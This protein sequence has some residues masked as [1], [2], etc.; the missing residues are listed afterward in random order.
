MEGLGRRQAEVCYEEVRLM[1]D[2]VDAGSDNL[3]DRAYRLFV[4]ILDRLTADS[5]LLFAGTYS[6]LDFVARRES[7]PNDLLRRLNAFRCRATGRDNDDSNLAEA[8]PFDVKALCFFIAAVYHTPVPE[9][10]VRRLPAT[11]PPLEYQG[12]VEGCIRGVVTRTDGSLLFLQPMDMDARE[13]AVCCAED[14]PFGDFTY[15]LSIVKT[16]TRVNVIRPTLKDGVYHPQLV[17]VMPDLLIDISAVAACFESYAD[18][19][20]AHL[21]NLLSPS[22]NSQAILLGNFAGQLLDEAVHNDS[23]PLPYAQ[24]ARSF[25]RQSAMKLATCPD[26]QPQF[27]EDAKAQQKNICNIVARQ[28]TQLQGYA[29]EKVLLEPSF[30]CEMLGLQGRMD[31]LQTDLRVL[32]EQKSGKKDW[33]GGHLEKHYVQML[34][35]LAL[36]HYNYDIPNNQIESCLLYSKY[37]DGLIKEGPAPKLLFDAMR[38]RN[39]IAVMME[40]LAEGKSRVLLDA[41]TP[42]QLKVKPMVDKFWTVYIRPKLDAV[43]APIHQADRLTRDYFHRMFTFV[44]REHIL[45]KVGTPAREASGLAALWNASM[46]EKQSAGN[47]LA[48]LVIKQLHDEGKGQGITEVT[49]SVEEAEGVYLPNFREADAVIVYA[50]HKNTVPDPTHTMVFRATMMRLE[51][52][53]VVIAL[54]AP[55][56]NKTV[57]HMGDENIRWALEHDCMETTF[58]TLYRS[59]AAILT[60]GVDRRKLILAQ[61]APEVNTGAVPV[62]GQSDASSLLR[63]FVKAKDYFL[64]IGPPGTGKTSLGLVAMLQ[65]ELAR[66]GTVL[67]LSYTN[68]AVNEICSKLVEQGID[69]LRL[70]NPL[71]CPERYQDFLLGKRAENCGNVQQV[72]NLIANARVMV[73]TTS[74]MLSNVDL[75]SLRAFSLS[76]V[77]EASQILEPHLLGILCAKHGRGEAIQRFVLIGDHK[78][79]PAVVQQSAN[80]SIVKE[81]NLRGIGLSDCRL[82]L[83]ERLLKVNAGRDD[84]VFHFTKQG[85]MH[86]D[87]AGF[88]NKA[89]YNDRLREVPLSHQLEDLSFADVDS[90]DPAQR[91]LSS[92]RLLFIASHQAPT[93]GMEKVNEEEARI[94]ARLV[95]AAYCLY[96]KDKSRGFDPD[97][98]VGVIVPYRHQIA[99]IRRELEKYG[100][101]QLMGISIDTVERFQGSQREVIIYGFT[102]QKPWQLDF[103][104]ANVFVEDGCI[105]DRKLNVALTRARQQMV[106]VGNPDLLKEVEVFAKLID[107]CKKHGTFCEYL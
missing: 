9:Q 20:L 46:G 101:P 51:A 78:Q 102:V 86:H 89:F 107:Y 67:L 27:H 68:R 59:V 38:I 106:V 19:H 71:A 4:A 97:A 47:I 66:G 12:R 63:R 53:E 48:P 13:V 11:F 44:A 73:S 83:F 37:P 14:S 16:G 62:S 49:L 43:L 84:I 80:D 32:V 36:L 90:G 88:A 7:L 10:L 42:D 55:Q 95:H 91:L 65:E 35:Y 40:Q 39:N 64:L 31:L 1:L 17:V 34:L 74:T 75:F 87:V 60:A 103:L 5:S 50:F 6:K 25:F 85:R 100:I 45:A 72:R 41:L 30:F 76:I 29:P 81:N 26:M 2:T 69:F 96:S 8:W 15:V 58:S 21:L 79:L 18:T 61:R 54:R 57:F 23:R 92:A 3:Y 82:S 52:G 93:P 77:D 24:S 104:T 22:A 28:L 33:K 98:T 70:G 94:I 99:T 105:I 56:K